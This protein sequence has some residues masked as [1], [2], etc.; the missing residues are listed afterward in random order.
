MAHWSLFNIGAI[1]LRP[2]NYNNWSQP[3]HI[4]RTALDYHGNGQTRYVE[5][6]SSFF[7]C[8]QFLLKLRT[9][10]GRATSRQLDQTSIVTMKEA[11]LEMETQTKVTIS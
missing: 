4:G 6:F 3:L 2:D 7:V 5:C 11:N 1:L 8:T 10:K 9:K